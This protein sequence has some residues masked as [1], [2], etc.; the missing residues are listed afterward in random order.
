MKQPDEVRGR[1][2]G[3]QNLRRTLTR[4]TLPGQPDVPP[5]RRL[6]QGNRG[7]RMQRVLV[8]SPERTP[9]SPCRPARAR[10]LLTQKKAAV[11]RRCPFTIILK[12]P[13]SGNV[14]PAL[15]V[16]VDPGSKTTGMAVLNE[17]TG[18]VVWAAELT[19]R[20]QQVKEA[21]DTRRSQRRG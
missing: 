21:L 9:L 17:A 15:R 13:P 3:R 2:A 6:P 20:G 12:Q 1:V 18:E 4:T 19:H 5:F 7:S 14:I 8:L 16:K 10:W 11:L